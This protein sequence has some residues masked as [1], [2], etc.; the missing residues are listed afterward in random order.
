MKCDY[1]AV[2]MRDRW[3]GAIHGHA[4]ALKLRDMAEAF[5]MASRVVPVSKLYAALRG[6]P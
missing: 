6:P 4:Q 2:F 5:G 3:S 1:Y